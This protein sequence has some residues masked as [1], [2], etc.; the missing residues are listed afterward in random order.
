MSISSLLS[1]IIN[2]SQL[3][4]SSRLTL[5]LIL[6]QHYK[7]LLFLFCG[8]GTRS[9]EVDDV[10]N[11]HSSWETKSSLHQSCLKTKPAPPLSSFILCSSSCA[12]LTAKSRISADLWGKFPSLRHL[13]TSGKKSCQVSGRKKA[14][15]ITHSPIPSTS[16][17]YSFSSPGPEP[18]LHSVPS[19]TG[20]SSLIIALGS[21]TNF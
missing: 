9:S 17:L 13:L 10:P 6:I 19:P 5:F 1:S 11:P 2:W 20:N 12:V 14:A 15:W 18:S 16:C 4:V 7:V 3:V 8:F 21:L